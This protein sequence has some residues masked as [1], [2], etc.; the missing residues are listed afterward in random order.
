MLIY[1]MHSHLYEHSDREI[2]EILE[3]DKT[4]V[5]VAVSDDTS[6]LERT[7]SL[8]EAYDDRVIPCG[9]YHPWN[10][11]EGGSV[12]EARR[13]AR[14]A[15]RLGV[16][17][18]GEVGLDRKFL[19]GSTWSLQVEVYKLFIGLARELGAMLNIHAPGAWRDALEMAVEGGV[20]RGMLHWYTGPQDLIMSIA[21]AGFYAS[22][23]PAIRIQEKHR[24]I[25]SLAPLDV[26]V[27]ESDSP[28]NYRGLRL[29]P[30]MVR[31]SM[32]TVARIK[33][34]SLDTVM[35]RA[36]MNSRRLLGLS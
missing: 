10:L 11:K 4:L 2:E 9:G 14:L 27:F 5:I 8:H 26:L 20:E 33:G 31:E 7:W 17:C 15:E 16:R 19:P 6:S 35:E 22:I 21:E 25:A 13:T 3:A 24:R 12:E 28:Y 1:D 18:I 34:V 32:E 36:Y 30:L 23:N 29:S